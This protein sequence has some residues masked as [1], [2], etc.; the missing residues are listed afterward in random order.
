MKIKKLAVAVSLACAGLTMSPATWAAFPG[1]GVDNVPSLAQFKVTFTKDFAFH[2]RKKGIP[3]CE[4]YTK[5]K[6]PADARTYTSPT[7]YEPNTKIGRSKA[8]LDGGPIDT[9]VGAKICDDGFANS[10]TTFLKEKVDESFFQ[11]KYTDYED[12]GRP[13]D[14]GPNKEGEAYPMEVHTQVLSFNLIQLN[15]SR[16]KTAVRAGD[17]A[18]CQARPSRSL[19]GAARSATSSGAAPWPPRA[20]AAP[21]AAPAA[22][23]LHAS[24]SFVPRPP[25][26]TATPRAA[27]A[28]AG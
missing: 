3:Y 6:C 12:D 14:E 22:P 24:Q 13:F 8:H 10:C 9:E 21:R 26:S 16:S 25:A 11:W 17:Q 1:A 23:P 18:P 4:S 2:L 15:N 19:C 7:L 5:E 27:G 28:A 20:L